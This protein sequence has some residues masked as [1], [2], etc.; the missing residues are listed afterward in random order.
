[1][2]LTAM[3][4]RSAITEAR[5]RRIIRDELAREQLM[6]E[7]FMDSLKAPFK[8]LSD[9]AK[10]YVADKTEEILEKL[11]GASQTLKSAEDQKEFFDALSKQEGGVTLKELVASVPEYAELQKMSIEAKELDLSGATPD[12]GVAESLSYEDLRTSLIL[13]EER[14]LQRQ[15]ATHT[16]LSESVVAAVA[17]AWWATV[18]AVIATCGLIG[19]SVSTLEKICKYL[20]LGKVA[21]SLGKV[22]HFVEKVEETF[23][24][25]VA[26]PKP[27]QYAAYRAMWSV[28]GVY[29]KAKGKEGEGEALDYKTFMSSEGKEERE[30][31]LKALHTAVILV[32]VVQALGH[33]LESVVEFVHAAS[34]SASEAINVATH[35]GE[36]AGHAGVEISN[37]SKAARAASIA[38]EEMA[39]ARSIQV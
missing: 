21:T 2:I 6:R 28:K 36:K 7:G 24:D 35:A 9:K 26:F 29:S 12:K 25:K 16:L 1:M 23:L 39:A 13:I 27:V 31:T 33:I 30:A 19:F 14:Y 10:K 15:V 17:G 20:G 37:L 18:K 34:S 22:H 11:K 5:L 38:G 3:R 8:K 32:L 4:K